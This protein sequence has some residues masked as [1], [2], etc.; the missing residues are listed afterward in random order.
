MSVVHCRTAVC[1]VVCAGASGLRGGWAVG[2]ARAR[3]LPGLYITFGYVK[4]PGGT[5]LA[6]CITP[7]DIGVACIE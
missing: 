6:L 3:C 7:Q 4:R 5:C 1:R 2:S